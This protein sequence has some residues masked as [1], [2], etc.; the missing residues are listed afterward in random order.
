MPFLSLTF[1][2]F[3]NLKNKT[4]DLCSKEVFF[5]GENG[6]GKSNILEALYMTSYGSSFRTHRDNEIIKSG[7]ENYGVSALFR[8]QNDL[9]DRIIVKFEKGKKRIEKNGKKVID[10]KEILNIIPTVVFCYDDLQFVVGEPE[11]RRF[12]IDQ[13]ISM[14]DILYLETIRRYKK[15]LK[16]RNLI[17]KEKKY[18][19]L[20]VYD[21]HLATAGIE[22][23][24]KREKTFFLFNR[25]FTK[26]YKEVSNLENVTV[27]Y[28]SN[29]KAETV[30]EAVK[31]LFDKREIDKTM[32]ITMSGPHRDRIIYTKDKN[33]FVPTASTGQ[34]RLIALVLRIVQSKYYSEVTGKKPI[35]LLDDVLLELDPEKRKKITSLLPEYD[36]MFCT[37]L[38]EEP[39]ERYKN[40]DTKILYIKDGDWYE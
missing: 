34:R 3:R 40:L 30:E 10:R 11:R 31:I 23:Q 36:Q 12:F 26:I 19:L 37:Y 2:N 4:L 22:M 14:Y 33:C 20:D 32:G 24:K 15:I 18:E 13:T 28:R 1:Q 5:V 27:Q 38:P 25:I 21:L 16:N 9:S 8:Q 6:Q 17:L 35:L 39:Y 7:M 29:W